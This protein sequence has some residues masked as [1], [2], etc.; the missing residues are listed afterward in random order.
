MLLNALGLR[1]CRRRNV[2]LSYRRSDSA[3]LARAVFEFLSRSVPG[4]HVF[5]DLDSIPHG[6]DFL[7]VI[8]EEVE[9]CDAFVALVGPGWLGAADDQGRP[10][11][12]SESDFVRLEIELALRRGVPIVVALL[13]GAAP[14]A[15]AGLPSAIAALADAPSIALSGESMEGLAETLARAGPAPRRALTVRERLDESSALALLLFSR[16]SLAAFAL[17]AAALVLLL[18]A[19]RW[20]WAEATTA[21]LAVALAPALGGGYAGGKLA[22]APGAAAGAIVAPLLVGAILIGSFFAVHLPVLVAKAARSDT[23]VVETDSTFIGAAGYVGALLGALLATRWIIRHRAQRRRVARPSL[24]VPGAAFVL[25]VA[26]G[27]AVLAVTRSGWSEAITFSRWAILLVAGAGSTGVA[28]GA[29]IGW[30]T[31]ESA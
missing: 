14:L 25:G 5:R 8:R 7:G 16:W 17:S 10:R 31:R 6:I 24:A 26:F 4:L 18:A 27:L 21:F 2:F 9:A 22:G 11:L 20:S 23:A 29:I 3:A 19:G 13:D 12:E 1:R 15:R 28:A 30:H